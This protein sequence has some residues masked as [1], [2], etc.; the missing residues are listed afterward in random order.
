VTSILGK[1]VWVTDTRNDVLADNRRTE[2]VGLGA[3]HDDKG[4]VAHPAGCRVGN[5]FGV[6]HLS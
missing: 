2:P 4:I 1:V 6:T 5:I 3:G